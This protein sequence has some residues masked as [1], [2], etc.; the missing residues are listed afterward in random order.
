[1]TLAGG[2][3]DVERRV[4][5][6]EQ[7]VG[8]GDPHAGW[9]LRQ[10]AASGGGRLEVA[11]LLAGPVLLLW[12]AHYLLIIVFS[13]LSPLVLLAASVLV[14]LPFGFLASARGLPRLGLWFVLAFVLAL[15]ATLGMSV[16]T[17]AVDGSAVLPQNRRDVI[18][19]AQFSCSIAL[20]FATGLI[21]G[22]M[23]WHRN[24]LQ[25]ETGRRAAW[26]YRLARRLVGA[27]YS[28]EQ[29]H[30][31]AASLL[32]IMRMVMALATITASV[33]S[34]WQKFSAG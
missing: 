5:A 2:T 16:V 30:R 22:R 3:A 4:A 28:A 15:A 6:L 33:Y 21:L 12:L 29:A 27:R 17:A 14:P 20:S 19:L 32:G 34:G 7:A 9:A 11:L 23:F 24:T 1:M 18:E 13:R 31:A 10:P 8:I 26:A 25:A